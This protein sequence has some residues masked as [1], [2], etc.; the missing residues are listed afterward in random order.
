MAVRVNT[1]KIIKTKN[2]PSSSIQAFLCTETYIL[3]GTSIRSWRTP[4]NITLG[5]SLSPFAFTTRTTVKI[6]LSPP[7]DKIG[8]VRLPVN[9]SILVAGNSNLIRVSSMFR[10][11]LDSLPQRCLA[12]S[13]KRWNSTTLS[14]M[15]AGRRCAKVVLL[16]MEIA[17]RRFHFVYH[18][19]DALNS[20]SELSSFAFSWIMMLFTVRPVNIKTIAISDK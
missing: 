19:G 4:L 7:Q 1:P 16:L 8:I 14:S 2:K 12:L 17:W 11:W 6:C 9:S 18:P 5:G 20:G 13:T 10:I 3:L 15:S